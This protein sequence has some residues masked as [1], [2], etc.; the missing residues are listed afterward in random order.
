MRVDKIINAV[1]QHQS[2]DGKCMVLSCCLT[3]AT[4]QG[5][6]ELVREV[7][8]VPHLQAFFLS[9]QNL[10]KLMLILFSK[11]RFKNGSE[12]NY[13]WSALFEVAVKKEY[14]QLAIAIYLYFGAQFPDDKPRLTPEEE[15]ITELKFTVPNPQP[16]DPEKQ[17]VIT[18]DPTQMLGKGNYGI[19]YRATRHSTVNGV[20]VIEPFVAKITKQDLKQHENESK[21]GALVSPRSASTSAISSERFSYHF[22][23]YL[24][25]QLKADATTNQCKIQKSDGSEFLITNLLDAITICCGL[26]LDIERLHSRRIIHKDIKL[27]NMACYV[28]IRDGKEIFDVSLIDGGSSLAI[29]EGM[30]EVLATIV[31][32]TPLYLAPEVFLAQQESFG[33]ASDIYA[34]A[35]I[36]LSLLFK[37]NPLQDKLNQSLLQRGLDATSLYKILS[38]VPYTIGA[39]KWELPT[40]IATILCRAASQDHTERP[41]A[42]ELR[43]CFFTGRK[44]LLEAQTATQ[45]AVSAPEPAQPTEVP[46][47][48][49]LATQILR[50][51]NFLTEEIQTFL[52]LSNADTAP[53]KFFVEK[54]IAAN[55]DATLNDELVQHYV[56]ITRAFGILHEKGLSKHSY[57]L[58]SK[59]Q[60]QAN[61][62]AIWLIDANAKSEVIDEAFVT[63]FR[64][65]LNAMNIL[66]QHSL[67][68][69]QYLP[70][71]HHPDT[72]S[73]YALDE[74]LTR[75][76]TRAKALSFADSII[77]WNKAGILS[78]RK[79]D[80]KVQSVVS[81]NLLDASP[82]EAEPTPQNY[83]LLRKLFMFAKRA[84]PTPLKKYLDLGWMRWRHE[85]NS[86][87]KHCCGEDLV[88]F[89][90]N[91]PEY[92]EKVFASTEA[93]E[94]LGCQQIRELLQ[95][96]KLSAKIKQDVLYYIEKN[97]S[98]LIQL[99]AGKE[100]AQDM[101][102]ELVAL[103]LKLVIRK[104]KFNKSNSYMLEATDTRFKPENYSDDSYGKQVCLHISNKLNMVSAPPNYRFGEWIHFATTEFSICPIIQINHED[105]TKNTIVG[106]CQNFFDPKNNSEVFESQKPQWRIELFDATLF[107]NANRTNKKWLNEVFIACAPNMH[108]NR[109]ETDLV[110]PQEQGVHYPRLFHVRS[111]PPIQR[112]IPPRIATPVTL[113]VRSP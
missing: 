1:Y 83:S 48:V 55:K 22:M 27:D 79:L 14:I 77:E 4:R 50:D 107:T 21:F 42:S 85:N 84:E 58:T 89:M 62:F 54:I 81:G 99:M 110:A 60:L 33:F 68:T 3:K 6:R 31:G 80:K 92:I 51:R 11:R 43:D 98:F 78:K 30:Q 32:A 91:S 47:P 71:F 2:D 8:N 69:R 52:T 38:E 46:L 24:P 10:E 29:A 26:I 102:G 9:E 100:L 40:E 111:H 109:T 87:F 66:Q 90:I 105:N 16:Q 36:L 20:L 108:Q 67:L 82:A 94:K 25:G 93:R 63:D 97:T 56:L 45:V 101:P 64:K 17:D 104:A 57:I 96:E 86:P 103:Y 75:N 76:S 49:V 19:V 28:R 65:I 59:N 15:A 73:C 113:A 34:L 61:Y 39:P 95:S 88:D 41:S 106:Y 18:I 112:D 53:T 35:P 70:L 12:C 5:R 13:D 74:A 72:T 23:P 44:K 7:L 37:G